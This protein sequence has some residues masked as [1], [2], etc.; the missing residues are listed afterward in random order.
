MTQSNCCNHN[1]CSK[2][3]P[4]YSTGS[5]LLDGKNSVVLTSYKPN[6]VR[7]AQKQNA[8]SLACFF[9]ISTEIIFSLYFN[10]KFCFLRWV[11]RLWPATIPIFQAFGPWLNVIEDPCSKASIN[12]LPI[13][14]KNDYVKRQSVG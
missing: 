6:F 7:V 2:T 12:H 4:T 13:F 5:N 10:S 1:A 9:S 14:I 11:S 8:T 3:H